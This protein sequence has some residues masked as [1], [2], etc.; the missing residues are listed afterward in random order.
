[1]L[2]E[3]LEPT[4]SQ[5]QGLS[6]NSLLFDFCGVHGCFSHDLGYLCQ[7]AHHGSGIGCYLGRR[8]CVSES[9]DRRNVRGRARDPDDRVILLLSSHH[10]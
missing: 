10:S 3:P 4:P 1:M 6:S 7:C 8:G 2:E 9:D 5:P